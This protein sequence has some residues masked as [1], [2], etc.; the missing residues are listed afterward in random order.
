MVTKFLRGDIVKLKAT[1]PEGPIIKLKMSEEGEI[2]YLVKWTDVD[3]ATQ[4]RWFAEDELI[5]A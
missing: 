5:E 4:E 3:G 1:V 2:T